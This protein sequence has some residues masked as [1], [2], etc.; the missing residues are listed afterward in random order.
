[1]LRWI[2]QALSVH[3]VF[4]TYL[5]QIDKAPNEEC[6]FCG[7]E[8]TPKH[9]IFQCVTGNELR[10]GLQRRGMAKICTNVKKHNGEKNRTGEGIERKYLKKRSA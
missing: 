6:Y 8:D 10:C 3:G 7:E 9:G 1:M 5:W 2:I 4:N